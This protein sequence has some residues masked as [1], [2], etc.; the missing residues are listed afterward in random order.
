MGR[1]Y[2]PHHL[3]SQVPH[4]ILCCRTKSCP[5]FYCLAQIRHMKLLTK[6]VK[7]QDKRGNICSGSCVRLQSVTEGG[8]MGKGGA[9]SSYLSR[10]GR[11]VVKYRLDFSSL[12]SVWNWGPWDNAKYLYWGLLCS[13]H[14]L[15]N[16]FTD[17][18]KGIAIQ[19]STLKWMVTPGE[20]FRVSTKDEYST[21][22]S[23]W[24]VTFWS[25][26]N[27]PLPML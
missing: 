1:W 17:K 13:L 21:S 25:G 15:W 7:K 12:Y 20:G 2:G 19:F 26:V 11:R 4:L 18:Q 23:C 8:E 9:A 6:T 16:L 22:L 10:R 3:P 27:P 24:D 5:L 14:P